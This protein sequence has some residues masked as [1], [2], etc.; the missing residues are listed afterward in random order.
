MLYS[1]L[2]VPSPKNYP[3]TSMWYQSQGFLFD[4]PVTFMAKE[5]MSENI[6]GMFKL[7]PAWAIKR[8]N[9]IKCWYFTFTFFN[10]RSF[11]EKSRFFKIF[12]DFVTRKKRVFFVFVSFV[13]LMLPIWN[14]Y[15]KIYRLN[16]CWLFSCS[17][18]STIAMNTTIPS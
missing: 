18:I 2:M 12:Q 1:F 9:I 13:H 11:G 5:L 6:F 17:A 4:F 14:E 16:I 7:L 3:F 10:S 15:L 8:I